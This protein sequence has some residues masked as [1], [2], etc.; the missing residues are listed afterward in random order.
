MKKSSITALLFLPVFVVL[1][2]S[3]AVAQSYV[4]VKNGVVKRY[5]AKTG[6]YKVTVGASRASAASSDG[7]TNAVLMQSGSVRRYD[8]KTGAYRGQVGGGKAVGVQ[9]TGGVIIVTYESGSVRRYD[10]R[11]GAYKGS[12]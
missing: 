12:N 3:A 8:A 5:D 1:L 4:V 11:T 6:A 7:E 9:V 2:Y 10:A